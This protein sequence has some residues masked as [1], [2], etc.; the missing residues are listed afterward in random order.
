MNEFEKSKPDL[1]NYTT[2]INGLSKPVED[3]FKNVPFQKPT[4]NVQKQARN[5]V[6]IQ[7]R[8]CNVMIYNWLRLSDNDIELRMLQV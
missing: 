5:V 3:A 6:D 4:M 1:I 7:A 8:S 2:I